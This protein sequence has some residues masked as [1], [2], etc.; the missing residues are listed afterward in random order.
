MKGWAIVYVYHTENAEWSPVFLAWGGA[1]GTEVQLMCSTSLED[2]TIE[3]Y[4]DRSGIWVWEGEIIEGFS[5]DDAVTW[6][7]EWRRARAAELVRL[8]G[9]KRG[10]D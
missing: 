10:E 2:H 1:V 8:S 6:E 3:D 4:P 9:G 7:G 5:P